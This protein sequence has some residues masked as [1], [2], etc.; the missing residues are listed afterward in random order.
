MYFPHRVSIDFAEETLTKTSSQG[1]LYYQ[2]SC[3]KVPVAVP[4]SESRL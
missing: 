3:E 1:H 4:A 2:Q